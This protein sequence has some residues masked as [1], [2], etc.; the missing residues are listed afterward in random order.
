[1][2]IAV[3]AL[4]SRGDVQPAIALAARLARDAA[5]TLIAPRDFAALSAGRGFAFCESARSQS[6]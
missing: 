5:A 6:C 4:G 1:L 2:K 3:L